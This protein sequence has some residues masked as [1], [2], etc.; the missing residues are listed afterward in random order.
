[1]QKKFGDKKTDVHQEQRN[2]KTIQQTLQVIMEA[3]I[4]S[5]VG[6]LQG[7]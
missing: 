7:W 6:Q 2:L 5:T 3:L 4:N 1:L